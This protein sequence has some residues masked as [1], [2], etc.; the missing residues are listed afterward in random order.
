[1]K[2]KERMYQRIEQ[3]GKNLN[4]IFGLDDKPKKVIS[5]RLDPDL[6]KEVKSAA[7]DLNCNLQELVNNALIEKIFRHYK[8]RRG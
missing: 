2:S 8:E 3:H 6:W 5:I 7:I 4:T 1:M